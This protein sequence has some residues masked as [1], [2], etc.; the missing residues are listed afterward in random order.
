MDDVN[1]EAGLVEE[2]QQETGFLLVGNRD[3]S[4]PAKIEGKHGFRSAQMA[5]PSEC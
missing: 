4:C 2:R 1:K 3:Q 5:L